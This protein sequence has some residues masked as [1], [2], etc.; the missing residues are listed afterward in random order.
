MA[1]TRCQG[2]SRSADVP[3][4]YSL[5]CVPD[6]LAVDLESKDVTEVAHFPEFC[7]WTAQA[8][9]GESQLYIGLSHSSKLHVTNGETTR[10]LATN[11]NSFTTTPGFL[12]YTTTAH[13]AHFAPLAELAK[14][15]STPDAPLPEFET[16]RVER[17]SR[18]VTAVPST[19]SLVLQMPRGNLETINPRPLVMEIVKQDIDRPVS[20]CIYHAVIQS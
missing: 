19:M 3:C 11:A 8:S 18:I 14:V 1:G 2:S 16:R 15:L 5:A 6:V 4:R 20:P 9:T 17:G 13:V 10:T 12:I 7:F